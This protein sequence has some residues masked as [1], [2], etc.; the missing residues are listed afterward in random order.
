VGILYVG[1][2]I[3]SDTATSQ[4]TTL[5]AAGAGGQRVRRG[6]HPTG[7]VLMTGVDGNPGALGSPGTSMSL[8]RLM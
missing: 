1:S 8:L 7:G 4:K 5:G 2:M 6:K 3:T